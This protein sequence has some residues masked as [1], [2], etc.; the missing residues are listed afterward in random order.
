MSFDFRNTD[1]YSILVDYYFHVRSNRVSFS[2]RKLLTMAI[3]DWNFKHRMHY[4]RRLLA[5]LMA[6]Q[7][8]HISKCLLFVYLVFALVLGGRA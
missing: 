1:P 3:S 2:S 6:R 5:H 7:Y 4:D 8:C